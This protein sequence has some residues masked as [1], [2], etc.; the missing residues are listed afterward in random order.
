MSDRPSNQHALLGGESPQTQLYTE[1]EE[2]ERAQAIFNLQ[3]YIRLAWRIYEREKSEGT[4][5]L[6]ENPAPVNVSAP[7]PSGDPFSH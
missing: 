1:L 6:T 3:R 2:K 5:H 4:K 7:G